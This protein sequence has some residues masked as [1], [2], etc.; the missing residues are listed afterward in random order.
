[1]EVGHLLTDQSLLLRSELANLGKA[2]DTAVN[3]ITPGFFATILAAAISA[4][5]DRV[6]GRSVVRKSHGYKLD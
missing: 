2:T 6:C 3:N 1:M 4:I 5:K